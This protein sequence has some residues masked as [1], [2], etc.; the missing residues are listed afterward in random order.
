MEGATWT[1]CSF[2]PPKM[3]PAF[4]RSGIL[5]VQRNWSKTPLIL[6]IL[7]FNLGS[8]SYMCWTPGPVLNSGSGVKKNQ[9]SDAFEW[10]V[11]H[12]LHWSSRSWFFFWWGG[13]TFSGWVVWIPGILLWK[14]LLVP[15]EF[16]TT[17]PNHWVTISWFLRKWEKWSMFILYL[18][19]SWSPH[20]KKT[21]T[22]FGSFKIHSMEGILKLYIFEKRGSRKIKPP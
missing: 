22:R 8:S 15:L 11:H 20:S 16:Q 2:G 21:Q 5:R 19:M 12:T 14:G 1:R 10:R 9:N 17:N 3:T 4:E 7:G 18:E 6:M 13:A